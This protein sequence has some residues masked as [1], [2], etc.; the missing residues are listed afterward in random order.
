VQA[1]G[2]QARLIRSAAT[3]FDQ[4]AEIVVGKPDVCGS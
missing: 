4:K 2:T 3:R 1:E